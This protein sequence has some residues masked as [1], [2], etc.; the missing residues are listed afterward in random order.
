MNTYGTD[1]FEHDG[2]EFQVEFIPDDDS[3]PPQDRADGH[4]PVSDWT[5]RDK[6]A[7]ERIIAED[8]AG[9]CGSTRSR[10]FY[11]VQEAMKI[12]RRDGWDAKPYG[13]GTKGQR[14]ARA[15][16][17]DFQF[18][19]GWYH[20]DWHYVGVVVTARCPTCGEFCGPSESLWGVENSA[21]E[22]LVETALELAEEILAA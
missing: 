13:T 16:E 17:S 11:D 4:G 10:R 19:R 15:V 12:A 2:R 18:L 3:T 22:Y 6:A 21:D 14:A 5:S 7:G 8:S 9:Y 20:D 1:T